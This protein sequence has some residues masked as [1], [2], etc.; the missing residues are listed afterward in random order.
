[1][2]HA[3]VGSVQS[4]GQ[5]LVLQQQV[6]PQPSPSPNP[7]AQS[8]SLAAAHH[9]QQLA[10]L[11]P[12]PYQQQQQQQQVVAAQQL[13]LVEQPAQQL[14]VQHHALHLQPGQALSSA[15]PTSTGAAWAMVTQAAQPVQ[16]GGT[17]QVQGLVAGQLL[18]ATGSLAVSQQMAV[19]SPKYNPVS[20]SEG[21]SSSD[22][23]YISNPNFHARPYK[24]K[25][26]TAHVPV[27]SECLK[28][29]QGPPAPSA[30]Q[31][32]RSVPLLTFT[33]PQASP[34]PAFSPSPVHQA[35]QSPGN[36]GQEPQHLS[37][38][39]SGPVDLQQQQQHQQQKQEQQQ[40]QQ[41]VVLEEPK[42][43][44]KSKKCVIPVIIRVNQ[45]H[46]KTEEEE[47]EEEKEEKRNEEECEGEEENRRRR[48]CWTLFP[49]SFRSG[50]GQILPLYHVEFEKH[51]KDLPKFDASATTPLLQ[52]PRGI[53]NPYKQKGKMAGKDGQDG[54]DK[55]SNES[56]T[57]TPKTPKSGRLDDRRFFGENF[58]LELASTA[59]PSK[60][61]GNM[62]RIHPDH[63]TL[64]FQN[65]HADIFPN[66]NCLQLKIREVR[67][68]WMNTGNVTPKTPTTPSAASSSS[69]SYDSHGD[70]GSK[71]MTSAG[72]AGAAAGSSSFSSAAGTV[73]TSQ[74]MPLSNS[75][76][77][78]SPSL[79]SLAVPP[80]PG[81]QQAMGGVGR[82][83]S[84]LA[85]SP[86]AA[87]GL[88]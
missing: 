26:T 61:L 55:F 30:T 20:T 71:G 43:G 65:K 81:S 54:G 53:L 64:A 46:W 41:H 73:A 58:N 17:H 68:K 13:Q 9:H 31:A 85:K 33:S 24:V 38:Q 63:A 70:S 29:G 59:I 83:T 18:T 34:A 82:R 40:Q 76:S 45:D 84:P 39:R 27:A 67:Q 74:P 8:P 5:Q 35:H 50:G 37:H 1:M 12:H 78:S 15:G 87:N 88:Q 3:Y 10:Q 51:F 32:S 47:K 57:P 2:I 25:A 49:S 6:S 14:T 62:E 11:Q 77:T 4:A 19:G 80:L 7:P 23:G 75:S 44:R 22:I 56:G 21:K 42:R 79:S 16:V 36:Y 72:A 48:R 69:S 86:L 60:M 66:K 52:S 28:P